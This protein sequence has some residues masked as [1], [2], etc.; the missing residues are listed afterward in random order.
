MA[1]RLYYLAS[2]KD[3]VR[4]DISVMRRAAEK[5]EAEVAKAEQEKQRQVSLIT[6]IQRKV[7]KMSSLLGYFY[8]S[9]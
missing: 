3:N 7:I 5:V 9:S 8:S 4:S 6:N 1:L 2:A